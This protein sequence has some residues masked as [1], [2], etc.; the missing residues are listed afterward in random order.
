MP[1]GFVVALASSMSQRLLLNLREEPTAAELIDT[2][3][4]G[5]W[6]VAGTESALLSS[7]PASMPLQEFNGTEWMDIG[8]D[9]RVR[10]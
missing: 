1:I 4:L 10:S 7:K 3:T 5:L 9:W 2:G 6:A 8:E